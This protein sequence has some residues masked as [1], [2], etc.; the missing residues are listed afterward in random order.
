MHRKPESK[1]IL[2][3][4]G[5][6]SA[7]RGLCTNCHFTLKQEVGKKRAKAV[8]GP[9]CE[10]C[11]GAA[12]DWIEFHGV[13]GNDENGGKATR[14]TEQPFHKKERLAKADSMGMIRTHDIYNIIEN[15]FECHTIPNEELVNI[16]GHKS[17]SDINFQD[18]L[19]K[20]IK[21]NFLYSNGTVNRDAPRDYDINQRIIKNNL[22]GLLVDLEFSLRGFS[23]STIEGKYSIA[24]KERVEKAILNLND[25]KDSHQDNNIVKNSLKLV[26]DI[27]LD[28]YNKDELIVIAD[29]LKL[30][31]QEYSK[32]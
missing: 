3:N 32:N 1:Q 13:Y 8:S 9:S 20:E 24:M 11:H 26:N 17:G 16:G 27:Q 22:I 31:T 30:V 28:I 15:C 7:K 21:H 29:K 12:T 4:M 23:K 2:K 18:W 6:K 25:L 19:N 5:L 10:S 14:D